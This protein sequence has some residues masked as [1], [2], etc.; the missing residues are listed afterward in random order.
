MSEVSDSAVRVNRAVLGLWASQF[1]HA[2]P[3]VPWPM[4]S[5]EP[6]HHG[7]LVVGCNPALPERGYYRVPVFTAAMV[8]G[9]C[10]TENCVSSQCF[11]GEDCQDA[12]GLEQG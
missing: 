6:T 7:L 8:T 2:S 10:K 3:A 11:R 12:A 1:A 4:I 5:P 9:P